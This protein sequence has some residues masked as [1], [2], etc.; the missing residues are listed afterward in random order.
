MFARRGRSLSE[1]D[2]F[3]DDDDLTSAIVVKAGEAVSLADHTRRVERAVSKIASRCLP[4]DLLQPL[5]RSAR[6]HDAGKLDERFQ[7]LLGQCAGLSAEPQA[8][9][10]TLPTSPEQWEA[11]R[12]AA[13]LPKGFRHE[14]LSLQLAERHANV[15]EDEVDLVLH[16]IASHHGHARPFA[17]V[18]PDCKPPPVLGECP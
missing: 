10:A 17:P 2:L 18:V 3:A 9:S 4:P 7:H 12:A 5:L 1:S 11:A 16:L 8:K 14:M 15:G 13:D 6:R